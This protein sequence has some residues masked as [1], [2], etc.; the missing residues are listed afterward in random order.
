MRYQLVY[1]S[2]PLYFYK[3]ERQ[4]MPGGRLKNVQNSPSDK[5]PP[6]GHLPAEIPL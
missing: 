4:E 1:S 5:R 2:A 6:A 3:S